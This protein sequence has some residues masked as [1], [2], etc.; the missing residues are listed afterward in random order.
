[1]ITEQPLGPGTRSGMIDGKERVTGRVPYTIDLELPNM[2]HVKLL[3]SA[4]PHARIAHLDVRRARRVPGVLAVLTGQ[5]IVNELGVMPYY[6]PVML[7]QPILAIGKVRYVGEPVVAVAALDADVAQE[8]IEAVDV[9]YDDLVPVLDVR[10]AL[11]GTALVHEGPLPVA[12]GFVD[13]VSQPESG[14]NICAHFKLRRGDVESAFAQADYVFEDTFSNPPVQHVP[15]ETHV[16][17]AQFE[18]GHL[19]VWSA[20]QTPHIVRAQL[21]DTFGLP[22]SHVRV[23]VSTLG[24][25]YGAKCY[26]K[27]EPVTVALAALVHRP[28]RLHLSREEEFVTVSKHGA[29][30]TMRVGV[31]RDGTII[32]RKNT[33]LF[34]TGAYADIGPRVIQLGGYGS[35]GPYFTPNAWVDSMAL[36]TNTPPAGAFRGFGFAQG[37]W[38]YETHMDMIAE[39]LAMDPCE[40]RMKNLLVDGQDT[41]TGQLVHD[42]RWQELLTDAAR[43]IGWNHAEKPARN[44]SRVRAKGLSS[45]IC[46]T[47]TPSTS[48][49]TVKLNEDGSINV[50]TSSVEMGQGLKTA[51]AILAAERLTV[52]VNRVL[53]SGVDT[54]LTPYDQQTNASR[55]T[56]AM[57]TAVLTAADE[58]VRQLREL[59][60]ELLEVSPDDLEIRDGQIGVKGVSESMMGFR[61][62]IRKTRSGNILGNGTYRT[63]GGL[64][65]ETGQGIASVHFEQAAGAAEVEVDLETGRFEVLRYHGGVYAG[66]IVNPVQAELQTEGCIAF[67]LGQVL[68]E[69]MIFDHGQLQN[70][71]LG[72]YKIPSFEDMP[73]QLSVTILE[74]RQNGHIIGLGEPSLP[75]VVPAVGNAVFRAT[76]VRIC[77]LP[78]TPEKILRGLRQLDGRDS[79]EAPEQEGA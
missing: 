35:A 54:D 15:F 8:A 14:T 79:G 65:R 64:D 10:A 49:A 66:R 71:N 78:I 26:P 1:M 18:D 46:G 11:A 68:F 4:R 23:I 75:P 55:S 43:R 29:E 51:L 27:L 5:D 34:N 32:A 47:V 73:A 58:I 40:L 22:L 77:D 76:G 74:D 19:T 3:R 7:D 31:N 69:E 53:V 45:T 17:V 50:L 21:A 70:A 41:A 25:A 30:I 61:E 48:T 44:G 59:A 16:C 57:G 38:A 33:C 9:E 13:I 6:G 37:A 42:C 72:D 60:S 12:P 2:A 39:R 52:P 56:Y 63:K 67:G 62:V 24:G 28:V 20:T 36:Y